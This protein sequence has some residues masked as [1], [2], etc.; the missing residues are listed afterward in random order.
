MVTSM[1]WQSLMAHAGAPA[2]VT[3]MKQA[4][5]TKP[6]SKSVD[7]HVTA[8]SSVSDTSFIFPFFMPQHDL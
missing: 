7:V 6:E 5:E 8:G 3:G 4:T 2:G 1:P